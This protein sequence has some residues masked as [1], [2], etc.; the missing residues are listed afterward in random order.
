[1]AIEVELCLVRKKQV[2]QQANAFLWEKKHYGYRIREQMLAN[3]T[4]LVLN[5]SAKVG[6]V[7]FK[8]KDRILYAGFNK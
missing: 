2:V 3:K 5:D 6:S 4:D 7:H 1:V 8:W